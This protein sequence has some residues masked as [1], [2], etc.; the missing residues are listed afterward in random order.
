MEEKP[1]ITVSEDDQI[2]IDNF[3]RMFDAN[4][5][6]DLQGEALTNLDYIF[7]DKKKTGWISKLT[8]ER[9][10]YITQLA[11]AIKSPAQIF[12]IET[13]LALSRY[14]ISSFSENEVEKWVFVAFRKHG[15]WSGSTGFVTDLQYIKNATQSAKLVYVAKKMSPFSVPRLGALSPLAGSSSDI[16]I[17]APQSTKV[18]DSKMEIKRKILPIS[19]VKI[20]EENGEMYLVGYANTK[21]KADRYG[22]IPTVYRA[23]RDF[24]YDLAAYIKN[25]V[26]LLDHDNSI[27]S[28]AGSMV[29]IAED[30][31]GLPFKMRFS[32][33]DYPPVKHARTVY[34]EGHAR[35]ISIAGRFHFE[36]S[37]HP[38]HLTL[39][40]IYE[41]SL[42]AVP[43]DPDGLADPVEPP[44]AEPPKA[45][46]PEAVKPAEPEAP[47]FNEVINVLKAATA[48]IKK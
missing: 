29:Q 17:I 32:M 46:E 21:N 10:E 38:D 28:V 41:I 24:V 19:Q 1:S 14:Y 12:E 9:A 37:D 13:H 30:G 7:Y 15:T 18:K 31:N 48:A 42:V 36:D 4:T 8:K 2:V 33:S 3:L 20:L 25:P 22:D 45:A 35:G 40:E 43:A 34:T 11:D 6:A 44:A 27:K 16:N 47:A 39:A 26:V 5:Y 23:K